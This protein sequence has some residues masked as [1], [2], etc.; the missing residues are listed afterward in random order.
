MFR[1]GRRDWRLC[2]LKLVAA[3]TQMAPDNPLLGLTTEQLQRLSSLAVRIAADSFEPEE[4]FN[5]ILELATELTN[6]ELGSIHL[7]DEKKKELRMAAIKGVPDEPIQGSAYP[8]EHS[9]SGIVVRNK[10]ALI[11]NDIAG[12]SN[13][14]E[15]FPNIRSEL[16]V[17]LIVG[18]EVL[19]VINVESTK[20]HYFTEQHASVV[21]LVASLL[22]AAVKS[23]ELSR[24]RSQPPPEAQDLE[25]ELVFVLMPFR[26][27]FN[28]YYRT[29]FRPAVHEAGKRVLRS[30][31]IFGPSEIMRDLWGSLN[32][33]RTVLAELTGR[34]PNVMYEVGLAH[35][36]G[37]PVV[38]VAQSMEDVPFDLRGLRCILYDTTEPDWAN[39]L[40]AAIT[41]S[42]TVIS[43]A[44]GG[45]YDRETR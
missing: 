26:E 17:P 4:A 30:D 33:S 43:N 9:V 24:V 27:P 21:Q 12:E 1:A 8:L 44:R 41:K 6:S 3:N 23:S 42:L 36:I 11:L 18:K 25:A 29:I 28:K 22:A 37:K 10:A 7:L 34:N 15:V 20:A 39:Q 19:G 38:L 2:R 31:E 16:V 32:E 40:R 35:G 13:Y 5:Q 45:P 14:V